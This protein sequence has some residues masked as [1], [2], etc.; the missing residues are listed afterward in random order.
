MDEK[1]KIG[2]GAFITM[3]LAISGTYYFISPD[4]IYYC[5]SKDLVG[6]C[7]SLSSGIGTRCYFNETYK[8]CNE[9]WIKFDGFV[10]S[11]KTYAEKVDVSANGEIYSCEINNGSVY[12]YSHCISKTNKFAYMGELV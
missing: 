7:D 12:S 8:T 2:I 9:G 5:E 11:E 10:E 4:K 6:M 1:I 3:I